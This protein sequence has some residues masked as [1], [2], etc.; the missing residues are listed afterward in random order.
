MVIE[1]IRV[2]ETPGVRSLVIWVSYRL[3]FDSWGH[4][5]L[6]THFYREPLLC[7]CCF[8]LMIISDPTISPSLSSPPFTL[9]PLS[10]IFSHLLTLSLHSSLSASSL[11]LFIYYPM[12]VSH[13][14]LFP[15][16]LSPDQVLVSK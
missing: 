9:S 14:Y 12:Y 8:C 2:D 15:M 4:F 10:T 16:F 1:G 6:K 11:L 13:S 5:T 7:Q 3:Y